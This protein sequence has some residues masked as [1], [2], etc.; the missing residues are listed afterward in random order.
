ME[1]GIQHP[2]GPLQILGY[3]IWHIRQDFL[4]HFV[5]VYLDDI[6]I[7]SCTLIEH[8]IHVRQVLQRLLENHLFAK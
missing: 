6:L 5:F 4:N 7:F 2:P 8:I 3:A 1:D